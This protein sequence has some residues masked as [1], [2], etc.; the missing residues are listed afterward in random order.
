[1]FSFL[2]LQ[3]FVCKREF[4]LSFTSEKNKV[5]TE[6]HIYINCFIRMEEFF[7][8]DMAKSSRK[9]MHTLLM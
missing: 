2:W 3:S 9:F 7:I 8:C 4:E 1:M 5:Q 6:K